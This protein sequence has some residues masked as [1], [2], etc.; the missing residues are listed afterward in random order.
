MIN[1]SSK[2]TIIGAGLADSL[3]TVHLTQRGFRVDVFERRPDMRK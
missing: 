2:I 3:L 1:N